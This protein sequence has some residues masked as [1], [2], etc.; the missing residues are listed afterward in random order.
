MGKLRSL[1]EGYINFAG[2]AYK[3]AKKELDA[4]SEFDEKKRAQAKF[5]NITENELGT[6]K[7]NTETLSGVNFNNTSFCLKGFLEEQAEII[8]VA[9]ME[10]DPFERQVS[11]PQNKHFEVEPGIFVEIW[12]EA[13]IFLKW[14][15]IPLCISITV[16]SMTKENKV[17]FAATT[18]EALKAFTSAFHQYRKKNHYLRGKKFV[19]LSGALMPVSHYGWNDIVLGDDLL[20]RIKSEVEGVFLCAKQLNRYGLNSKKGFILAGDP[21]NGKTLLLKILANNITA[22]CIVVPFNRSRME[23]NVADIF[24]LARELAPA[25]VI[26]E[27]IDLY[28]SERGLSKDTERLGE[29]MNELDGMIDNNEIVVFATTNNLPEIEKALQSRPGRFDRIYKIMNP[30]FEARLRILTHFVNQVPNE[31]TQEEL[32]VLAEEFEGYSGA[33]L[34]E[35]VNSGFAQAVLRDDEKP[36]LRYSDLEGISEVLKN[37]QEKSPLGFVTQP[38]TPEGVFAR[39]KKD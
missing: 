13:T 23:A 19:G 4:E 9:N 25:V 35:L 11:Y 37:R 34:K 1:I 15:M 6:L 2:E 7:T 10:R 18:W 29:L 21:G 5:F 16:S 3:K 31:I 28:G 14:N 32:E 22:T 39:L 36:V 12:T 24:A 27:D 38:S 8:Q 20:S 30:D 33:Y 17:I 26:L